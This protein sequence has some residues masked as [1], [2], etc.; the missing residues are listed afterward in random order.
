MQILR[1]FCDFHKIMIEILVPFMY[2]VNITVHLS[3]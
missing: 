3:I 2:N 1:L